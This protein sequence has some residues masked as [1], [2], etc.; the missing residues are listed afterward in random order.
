MLDLDVVREQ[1]DEVRQGTEAQGADVDIDEILELDEKRRSLQHE[2]DQKR[3][4]QNEG[5]E[6]VAARKQNGEDASGLIEE[7]SRLSDEIDEGEERL[8]ELESEL[9]DKMKWL[10]N[11]PAEDVPTGDT[12]DDNEL[13]H[14]KGRRPEFDVDPAPHWTVGENL[15]VLDIDRSAKLAGSGFYVLKGAGARLERALLNWMLDLHTEENEY[16]EVQVPFL[17]RPEALY[18]TGQLPKLRRDMYRTDKDDL[19]L[20]PTSEVPLINLHRDEI[21]DEEAL[22]FYY[23]SGTAC[24]RR[25]AGAAGRDTRG[26]TRVHQFMKVEM[27]K[28][29]AAG[30]ARREL[31]GMISSAEEVLDRL[32]LHYRLIKLCTGDLSF[33]SRRTFDLEVWAPGSERWLEVSSISTCSDFQARRC[34]IRYRDEDGDLHYPHTLNGSGVALA[35]TVIALLEQNQNEDGTVDLPDPLVPYMNGQETLTGSDTTRN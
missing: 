12:E 23:T 18:G 6:E 5:S 27:I 1:P 14:K 26:M 34:D 28:I 29:C 31:N 16:R 4:R 19:F 2:L 10:P 35:R 21:L 25:E 7:L 8:R 13:I 32:G 20:I 24:F 22:P 30:N 33:A 9:T 11:L 17:S 15:D 3:H